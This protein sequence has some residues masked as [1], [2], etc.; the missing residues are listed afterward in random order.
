M[1]K[2]RYQTEGSIYYNYMFNKVSAEL[3]TSL[4]KIVDFA[5]ETLDHKSFVFPKNPTLEYLG[6]GTFYKCSN[7]ENVTNLEK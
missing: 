3:C 4:K 7:L 5:F 1:V 2:T 6:K